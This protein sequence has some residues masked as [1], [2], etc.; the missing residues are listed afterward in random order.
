M[1]SEVSR[2]QLVEDGVRLATGMAALGMQATATNVAEAQGAIAKSGFGFVH[3]TDT[4]IQPERGAQEGVEKAFAAIAKLPEKPAFGLVG[5]DLVMDAALVPRDRADKVYDMWRGAAEKLK[6]PL[7]YSIGNHDLYGLK[8]AGTLTDAQ[9]ADP[10]YGK[11]MWK[12]RLGLEQSYNSFDH[13]GWRFVTLDSTGITKDADW[14]GVLDTEQIKW[15]D[16]LL[17]RTPKT[18]PMIFLTHF[19]IFTIINQYSAGTTIP[20]SPG[21]VV[22]NGKTFF[23]MTQNHNVKAVFQG[24]THVVEEVTYLGT[25]YITGGAVCGDWWKGKRFGVHPEGFVVAKVS[26]DVL[27]WRYVP[28]GWKARS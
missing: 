17:R 27:S 11:G 25:H 4:H 22:K 26:G 5:G 16:D 12:K 21:M 2:R 9:A 8:N 23:E 20:L 14:E 10:E 7:H 1:S 13:Q 18:M 15:L 6:L 28:Y 3:I 19:P 24:H